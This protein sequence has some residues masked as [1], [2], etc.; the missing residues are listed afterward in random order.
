MIHNLQD[1]MQK[2]HHWLTEHRHV[3][4]RILL[5]LPELVILLELENELQT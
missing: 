1:P 3:K 4:I 5:I 2:L